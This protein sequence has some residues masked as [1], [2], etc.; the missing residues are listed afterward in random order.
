MKT[1]SRGRFTSAIASA[2]AVAALP[3]IAAAQSLIPVKGAITQVYYDAAPILY[4]QASGMFTKAGI[5]LDLGRLP[6]GAA[7]TAA[8]AGGSL[9]I[10]KSTFFAVVAAFAHGVP[11]SVIAP[12]V[13]YDSRSPNGALMVLE[14]LTDSR[15]RRHGR[16]GD[17]GEQSQ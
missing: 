1:L 2:G 8:V 7:V 10:G 3:R 17:R 4:A 5:D 11:I 9:D 14:R 13:I 6:T 12:G 16:Q 15:R